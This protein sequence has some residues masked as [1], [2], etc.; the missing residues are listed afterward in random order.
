MIKVACY[1]RVSTSHEDQVNSFEAQHRYFREYILR[2]TDWELYDVYADEGITGTSVRKRRHFLRM[3]D[4]AQRGHF[5]LILTK[6][7]SR[8]SRNI[9]DTIG[10][11]R[12]LKELGI[13][14]QFLTDGFNSLDPDAELRLSIMG[15]IAQ[16]ESRKTSLRVKWGQTRQMERG[17][18]FGTSLLGYQV[19]QGQLRID[20]EGAQLVRQIF[21]KYAV[22][23]KSTTMIA[24]ELTENG[25]LTAQGN[26]C[27]YPSGILRILKNEKY[28]GDLIQKKTYT[29]NY[30]THQKKTNHGEESF[31]VLRDHHEPII[32][33]E[34]WELTQLEIKNRVRKQIPD[35]QPSKVFLLSGKIRCNVCGNHFI[36]RTKTRKD[37]TSYRRWIC[38]GA[39]RGQCN[40]GKTL[41]DDLALE[42]VQSALSQIPM[43]QV[44]IT[45]HLIS[46]LD[47]TGRNAHTDRRIDEIQKKQLRSVDAYL[48][49]IITQQELDQIRHRYA[50][51]LHALSSRFRQTTLPIDLTLIRKR[52]RSLISCQILCPTYVGAMLEEMTVR[53]NG[54][55][56]VKLA[57]HPVVHRFQLCYGC[58]FE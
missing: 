55:V 57:Q 42:I 37:K 43:D 45:D 15:S 23:K 54:M 50:A 46:V 26:P 27:W 6:E 16:E 7:V 39:C 40:I 58:P 36:A 20:P 22:E 28:V 5:Q 24:K 4:D 38:Y 52:I 35:V 56:E 18:V 9:L 48:A 49:G 32:D 25:R 12:A 44:S 31:V 13:G 1:C 21:F 29:P 41:R 3:M 11:T 8:F 47:A 10:Y 30:L 17:V 2:R 33:R 53:E 14:V 34:L 19:Y 51:E